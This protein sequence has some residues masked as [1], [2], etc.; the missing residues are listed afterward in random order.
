[1]AKTL[2]TDLLGF[3][4][5]EEERKRFTASQR[6]FGNPYEGIG[7]GLGQLLGAGAKKL[8]N[9][10]DP[11]TMK[12]S[13]VQSAMTAA[14]SQYSVGTS[15]YF[16]E[17][18]RQLS[19]FP[20]AQATALQKAR[21]A[22][23]KEDKEFRETSK[24]IADNPEALTVEANKLASRITQRA[25]AAGI[26]LSIDPNT[27]A[28]KTPLTPEIQAALSNLPEA[29][30]LN[31]LTQIGTKGAVKQFMELNKPETMPKLGFAEDD[32]R[33]VYR[34]GT[35]Q[36]K[37]GPGGERVPYY[38]SFR[39]E[40]ADIKFDTPGE[41]LKAVELFQNRIKDITTRMGALNRSLVLNS[42]TGSGFSGSLFIQEVSS[43]FGD[44]QKAAKEIELLGNTGALDERI[45]GRISK[46][47][48]GSSTETQKAD[49]DAT[50]KAIRELLKKDYENIRSSYS[51]A[52]Q[53]PKLAENVFPTFEKQFTEVRG[54]PPKAPDSVSLSSV[55]K[56]DP[57]FAEGTVHNYVDGSTY[58]VI[59]GR[60][61]KQQKEQ[62]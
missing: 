54:L 10:E 43:I 39:K 12:V 62:Q 7:Y 14:G 5:V 11:Q 36:F 53:D 32:G 59:G 44:A 48:V 4:P 51:A 60:L 45:A 9:I 25:Q 56:K 35:D 57:K 49:R 20:S 40:A 15:Q 52:L 30:R 38:G 17:L 47:L 8:F 16:E 61:V 50:L 41:R 29:Q 13:T 42:R 3:D 37:L 55:Q 27:G 33:A 18:A 23:D 6:S 22:R 28:L 19:S 34:A 1:M 58:K 21:E 46:F 24:F 31:Q 26:D 2:L